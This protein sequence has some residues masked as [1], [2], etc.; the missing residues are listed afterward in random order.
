MAKF[1]RCPCTLNECSFAKPRWGADGRC[2]L[3]AANRRSV[4]Y[5]ESADQVQPASSRN[6]I[7][8]EH[9]RI[10]LRPGSGTCPKFLQVWRIPNMRLRNATLRPAPAPCDPGEV[11]SQWVRPVFAGAP[12][13]VPPGRGHE[14][15]LT[16]VEGSA[17]SRPWRFIR[18]D[19]CVAET[20]RPT[21][22]TTCSPWSFGRAAGTA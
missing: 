19:R 10:V 15:S 21:D 1:F 6:R 2:P 8:F 14:A 9:C 7:V 16:D 12:V 11:N 4:L 18:F 3:S 13:D 22:N 17:E 20:G 5:G